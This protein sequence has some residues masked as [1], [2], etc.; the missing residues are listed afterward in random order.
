M[1]SNYEGYLKGGYLMQHEVTKRQKLL[2]KNGHIME[3]GFA[4]H[5]VWDYDRR[6]I[7]APKCRI[8]EWDYYLI[9]NED[10]AVA[11]TIS[12]LAYLGMVS[13]SFLNLK[14]GFEKTNTVLDAMP[15]G[16]YKL[17]KNSNDGNAKFKNKQMRLSYKTEAAKDGKPM[18][19]YILCQY[20]NFLDGQDFEAKIC[21]EQPKM[22]SMCI[23]TPWKE[24]PTA[25][26]YNQKIA[27]MPA[28]GYAKLGNKKFVFTPTR[29]FG[30]LDWGRGVW[31]YDNTWYWGIGS[32][33]IDGVPFGFN[34]GY[35]FSDRSCASENVIYYN[36]K[37]HKLEDINFGIPKCGPKPL[38]YDYM[39]P[40]HLTS[41][42][43]RFE[44]TLT[45]I[46]DRHSLT[47]VKIIESTQH[48]IF[49]RIN[50]KAILDDGKTMEM[51]D[52]PCAIEVVHNR[53]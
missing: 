6:D 2:D 26:Y 27:C 25:F 8:K 49:G 10:Y 30:I 24:K 38:D 22:E 3:P 1:N 39:K 50:G 17:G 19:R 53:Y 51:K 47:D 45:P 34:L 13:V 11:F 4:R 41:S 20:P 44:A 12:D 5:L 37:V 21:L 40:W 23:A 28:T 33:Q 48:Q 36:N 14:E 35:G 32:G 7:H 42:D 9:Q 16:K 29:D 43:G 18:K 46:L 15:M 52:F 31:T